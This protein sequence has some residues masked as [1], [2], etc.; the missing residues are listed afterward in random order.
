M[1]VPK[2]HST[3]QPKFAVLQKY[4]IEEAITY[5]APPGLSCQQFFTDVL[6]IHDSHYSYGPPQ[7]NEVCRSS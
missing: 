6:Q 3:I 2:L 5:F 1:S 4:V 7:C